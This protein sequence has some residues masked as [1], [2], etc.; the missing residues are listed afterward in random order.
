ML[1]VLAVGS[2]E[3]APR[4]ARSMRLSSE[5]TRSS[6]HG[7]SFSSSVS[8][9]AFPTFGG[10]FASGTRS[11]SYHDVAASSAGRSAEWDIGPPDSDRRR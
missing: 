8:V 7:Q 5:R 9:K 11:A 6:W 3:H 1:A 2:L 4:I 10:G